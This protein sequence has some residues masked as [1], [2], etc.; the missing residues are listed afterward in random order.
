MSFEIFRDC[1]GHWCAR[2]QDGLVCGIFRKRADAERF[3]R[4]ECTQVGAV[5][6]FRS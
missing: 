2:R 3:A 5:L 1:A 4:R 6:A